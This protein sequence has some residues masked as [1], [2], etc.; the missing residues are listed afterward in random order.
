MYHCPEPLT[1]AVSAGANASKSIVAASAQTSGLVTG[2]RTGSGF[3]IT[4]TS[5]LGLTVPSTLTSTQYDV[6]EVKG[7]VVYVAPVANT[8]P[9]SSVEYHEKIT[10]LPTSF[11]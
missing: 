9:D 1:P 10:E 8:A 7:G 5:T 4:K 6:F 2:A 3:T 11:V